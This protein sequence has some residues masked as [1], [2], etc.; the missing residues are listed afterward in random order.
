MNVFDQLTHSQQLLFALLKL[1]L[2][3]TVP[4]KALFDKA[5]DDVW[6]EVYRLS[7]DQ[8]IKAIIFDGILLLPKELQPPRSLKL[9][10]AVNVEAIERR[11]EQE[12]AVANE[13]ADIFAKN[14]IKML[15]FKGIGLAQYYPVPK[16]REFGDI[17][18]YLFG[19]QKEGNRLL[20]QLGAVKENC[21][22]D[23]R[24]VG[25]Q[26][27]G[28]FIENHKYFLNK[29]KFPNT[30]DLEAH[31]LKT[32]ADCKPSGIV[33]AALFP[34]PDFNALYMICHAL[35]HFLAWPLVLRYL[36]DWALFLKAN[37]EAIDFDAY[38]QLIAES[39]LAKFADAFTALTVKYL[40]FDPELAPPFDSNPVLEDRMMLELLN[41]LILEAEKRSLLKTVRN[42]IKILKSRKGKYDIYHHPNQFWKSIWVLIIFYISH[43]ASIVKLIRRVS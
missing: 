22:M 43:P 40:D 14:G 36:C 10:W 18:I 28:I 31:L 34:P 35:V 20:V 29:S 3:N 12:L 30:T 21:D 24:T 26:Y 41:S 2:W 42:T 17:D 39:G 11:Y 8:G 37:K 19:K 25:L 27:K 4:D 7:A 5:D 6:K 9:T 33:D 38:R 1:A 15:L 13:L 16:H 32:L 23:M